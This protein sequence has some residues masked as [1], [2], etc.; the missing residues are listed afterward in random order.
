VQPFAR[1]DERAAAQEPELDSVVALCETRAYEV[2]L[3][4]EDRKEALAAFAAKRAPQ[5][6]GR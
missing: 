1:A 5:F 2:T 4:T 6:H 3:Y